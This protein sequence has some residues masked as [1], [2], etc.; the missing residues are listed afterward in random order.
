VVSLL[1]ILF[2]VSTA[3]T[4]EP[5]KF[6][7]FLDG[8]Y[9]KLQPGPKDGVKQRWLKPGVDF[10]RYN[11]IML[12]SVVFFLADDSYKGIEPQ[13]MKDLADRLHKAIFAAFPDKS[14]FTAEPGPDVA[15]IRFAITGLKQNKPGVS[16]VTS[17]I[18]VG[19]AVSLVKKGAGGS[20]S[21]SGSTS[22]EAMV[23]DSMTNGVIGVAV[24]ER[25]AGFTDRFSKWGSAEEAFQ[26][27]AQRLK[28][29]VDDTKTL[30]DNP[31]PK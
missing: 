4:D 11:R 6:S 29:F 17:I 2:A 15:R 31:A 8:Y 1:V 23:L 28:K 14:K 18:P 5:K 13:E 27:W 9:D 16:A 24:D 25:T 26:F 21:G 12:D 19:L 3:Y 30:K 22:M 7:G 20:W 10:T